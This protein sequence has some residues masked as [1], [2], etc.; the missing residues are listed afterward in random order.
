MFSMQDVMDD[1]SESQLQYTGP[2]LSYTDLN[3]FEVLFDM[4]MKWLGIRLFTWL[5]GV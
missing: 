1:V 5:Q 3:I 2:W 4:L